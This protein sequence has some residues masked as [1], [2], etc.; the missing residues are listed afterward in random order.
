MHAWLEKARGGE[1]QV[2]FVTGEA[3]IGKTTLL[4]TFARSV[5]PDRTVRICSGQCLEQYG[6]SEAYLPVLEA[7]RQLCRDDAHVVDA[8]ARTRRCG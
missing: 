8:A 7:I 3:G 2:V 6:M 5:A 1:R 4:E